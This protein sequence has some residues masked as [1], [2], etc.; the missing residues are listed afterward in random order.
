MDLMGKSAEKGNSNGI[1]G[2]TAAILVVCTL[3]AGIVVGGIGMLIYKELSS[4][5]AD[6]L[7]DG[8]IYDFE[9]GGY[10]KLGEY[11]GLTADVQPMDEDVYSGMI[12]EAEEAEVEGDDVV[13]DGDLVNIDFTG[14]LDGEELEDAS[15]E[16]AYVWIGKGEYV[17]DFE[18]GIV[19]IKK[20]EEKTI[21][22]KFPADYDDDSLAGKTVQF[23]IKV[24]EKFSDKTAQKVSGGT[25]NTVQ[26][27][28]EYEKAAQLEENRESKGELVWDELRDGVKVQ[29][30]PEKMLSR[31]NE[32][33][34]K[35][36]TSFAELSGM[37]V[38]ELLESFEM[39]EDGLEEIANETVT[40]IMIAKT[41]AAKE[42]ITMDDEYY[43]KA[44]L[45][46]LGSEEADD[47]IDDADDTDD[48]DGTDDVDDNADA[49]DAAE[50]G[51]EGASGDTQKGTEG[52]TS[53]D[54]GEEAETPR[55]L[56][57]LEAEFIESMGSRPRDEMLIERVKDFV[58]EH[59]KEG[60]SEDAA[61]EDGEISFE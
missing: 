61:D 59:A 30:V 24:H 21:D 10:I 39:D 26:E 2:K 42:G 18:K 8:E 45:E 43:K 15:E 46:V 52:R 12:S 32:D 34:T 54:T 14:K 60:T 27:Y 58:G 17:E 51:E 50:E 3:V 56:E 33:V 37:D 36:Y 13:T 7:A 6:K 44:L 48:A 5:S 38:N 1:K 16:D 35:M 4:Q 55:T 11:K 47:G 28:F 23:S 40:D 57:E 25:C 9:K 41:I 20:G 29:S 49:D 19:G 53:G 31:A 22:C